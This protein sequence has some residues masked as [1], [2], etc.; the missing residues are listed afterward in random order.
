MN[1]TGIFDD[2]NYMT[3]EE[4]KESLNTWM[5]SV[6]DNFQPYTPIKLEF[7]DY[8]MKGMK[9]FLKSPFKSQWY[10]IFVWLLY[11]VF[12]SYM[13]WQSSYL[14]TSNLHPNPWHTVL[15]CEIAAH[16]SMLFASVRLVCLLPDRR[17]QA[18]F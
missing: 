13:G 18:T 2:L 15:F 14:G 5:M 7:M 16:S 3:F 1:Y 8:V 10:L 4:E 17:K 6:R 11:C 12:V 9:N